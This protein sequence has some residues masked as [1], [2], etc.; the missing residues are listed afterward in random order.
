MRDPSFGDLARMIETALEPLGCAREERPYAPH[1]TLA[2][3][4]NQEIGG[5]HKAVEAMA[6]QE[7]GNFEAADFHLYLSK[8]GA[9]SKSVYSKLSTYPLMKG[10]ASRV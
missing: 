10:I 5:L 3:I 2:R 4:G 9:R 8:P 7:F 1:L 6:D